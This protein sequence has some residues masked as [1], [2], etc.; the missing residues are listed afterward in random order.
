MTQ[1]FTGLLRQAT[2]VLSEFS[3]PPG[4]GACRWDGTAYSA[5]DQKA[6]DPFAAKWWAALS[7]VAE[8]I[9]RQSAPLTPQQ[10]AYLDRLLF[11]GMG[12]FNDFVFDERR[13]GAGAMRA[14]QDLNALRRMLFEEFRRL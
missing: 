12:S 8:M 11:G 13:A 9:E 2:A 5:S 1:A 3:E 4:I 10:K 7:A 6:F 14:N